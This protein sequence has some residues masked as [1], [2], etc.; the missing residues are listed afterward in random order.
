[1]FYE[2]GNIKVDNT[3]YMIGSKTIPISSISSVQPIK[4]T[5]APVGSTQTTKEAYTIPGSSKGF[6]YTAAWVAIVIILFIATLNS[7]V[8][9]SAL[10][11]FP[12]II[13]PF[14]IKSWM[15]SKYPSKDEYIKAVTETTYEDVPD[16]YHV[17]ITT[18]SGESS[19][20]QNTDEEKILAIVEAINQAIIQRG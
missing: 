10:H 3:R 4:K 12:F 20:Y 11:I 5:H 9:F 13:G 16:D 18:A 1:M 14:V 19:T 2:D 15:Y 17:I 7:N 6:W 8:S